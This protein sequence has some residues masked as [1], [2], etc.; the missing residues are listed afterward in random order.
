MGG[1]KQKGIITY[2]GSSFPGVA[3][4]LTMRL[5]LLSVSIDHPADRRLTIPP[6]SVPGRHLRLDPQRNKEVI[7]AISLLFGPSID[8]IRDLLVGKHQVGPAS[9]LWRRLGSMRGFVDGTDG[10]RYAY[11]NSK[12]GHHAIHMAEHGGH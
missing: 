5:L 2:S 9:A 7:T 8:R 10:L 3:I 12:E 1:P 6:A 4:E 11:N